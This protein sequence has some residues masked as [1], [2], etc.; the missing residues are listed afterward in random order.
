[1]LFLVFSLIL[2]HLFLTF[3]FCDLVLSFD[4]WREPGEY[5]FYATDSYNEDGS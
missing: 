1:M 5:E 2:Y 3:F 4:I